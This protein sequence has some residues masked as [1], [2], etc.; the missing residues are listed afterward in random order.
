M[1]TFVGQG[2]AA[3]QRH[4][5]AADAV[6]A[7]II[8]IA[9]VVS[10]EA[11]YSEMKMMSPNVVRPGTVP[12]VV[13]LAAIALPLAW[14]RVYP[15]LSGIAVV[16]AFLYARIVTEV[17][18]VSITFLASM[19]A[20]YSVAVHSQ[21]HRIATLL[22]M[23][24]AILAEVARELFY[25]NGHMHRFARGVDFFY[26][27]IVLVLPWILGT[28]IRSMRARQRELAERAIELQRQREANA[29]RAVF[30]ERCPHRTRATRRRC[31]SRAA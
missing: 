23:E 16:A 9:A 15:N 4:P 29:T 10:V 19:L 12:T 7:L 21:R 3:L 14:R 8:G 5:F 30:A 13:S 24:T 20:I 28:A 22:M 6:L 31:P 11:E 18:E 1:S 27:A 2:R 25:L 17:P 26:N